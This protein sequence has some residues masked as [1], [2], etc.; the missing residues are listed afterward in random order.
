MS[1]NKSYFATAA[2]ISGILLLICACVAGVVS[3]VYSLTIDAYEANLEAEINNALAGIFDASEQDEFTSA[4][5]VETDEYTL[6]E[7][8]KNGEAG[9]CIN[10]N[11]NGFGGAVSIMIGYNADKTI[12]GVS[13]VSHAET[14][15]IGS[16]ATESA[17]LSQ[18]VGKSGALTISKSGSDDIT[19]ISGATI[20]SKAIH[21]AIN[22]A[23]E[24]IGAVDSNDTNS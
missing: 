22:R 8:T 18:Y 16:K 7:V 11:G 20:S 19:A 15:G 12:R 6:Y 13:V 5:L 10:I 17:H 4:S 24:I 1:S 3:F 2:K 21:A 23:N 14:P 9:Y